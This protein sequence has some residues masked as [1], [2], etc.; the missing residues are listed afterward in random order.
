MSVGPAPILAL[1]LGILHVSIYVLIRG[2]AGQRLPWLLLAAFLG[3][4]A[5]DAIGGRLGITTLQVGDFHVISASILAWV[6]IGGIAIVAI[7]APQPSREPAAQAQVTTSIS[8]SGTRAA[9]SPAE[10]ETAVPEDL[11]DAREERA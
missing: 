10:A 8:R 11:D 1:L 7:L 2:S 3:A 9:R 5:G 6:G 4:W